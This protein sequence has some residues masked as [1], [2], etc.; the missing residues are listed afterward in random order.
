[1]H[2]AT[3]PKRTYSP[4][5]GKLFSVTS[6]TN[7]PVADA[8]GDAAPPLALDEVLVRRERVATAVQWSK[9]IGY[10]CLLVSCIAV[11]FAI[12][13]DLPRPLITLAL[14]TLAAACC[15]LPLP[16]V[17]GYGVRAADRA[18]RGLPDGH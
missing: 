18:D 17:L 16:I 7:P 12:P 4:R 8:E 15:I 9:R 3:L 1:L 5:S 2:P 14:A 6:G 10:S 13:N 11:A